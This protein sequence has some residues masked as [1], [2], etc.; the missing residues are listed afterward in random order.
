MHLNRRDYAHAEPLFR[1]SVSRADPMGTMNFIAVLFNEGKTREAESVY[2]AARKAMPHF[3][4]IPRWGAEFAYQRGQLDTVARIADSARTAPA[5]GMKIWGAARLAYLALLRG[6][7]GDYERYL[8]MSRATD[9]ARGSPTPWIEDSVLFAYRDVWMGATP[10]ARPRPSRRR[11][12]TPAARHL[13]RRRHYVLAA[14]AYAMGGRVDRARSCSPTTTR[15]R[16]RHRAAAPRRSGPPPRARRDRA[17]RE[18]VARRDRAV[19]ARRTRRRSGC[20]TACASSVSTR[21][22]AA[23]STAPACQIRQ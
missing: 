3:P 10:G 9:A 2:V 16:A 19:P 15:R 7:A 5:P 14:R 12:R 18:A 20:P 21:S 8:K 6:R 23:P 13:D 17:R 4:L 22:W 1:V 11:A